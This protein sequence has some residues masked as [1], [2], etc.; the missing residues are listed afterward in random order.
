MKTN[1]HLN[2]IRNDDMTS[3]DL[4]LALSIHPKGTHNLFAAFFCSQ[5]AICIIMIQGHRIFF[6][7]EKFSHFF[8]TT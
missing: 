5:N 6:R 2:K 3:D 1:F 8:S 4:L 7:T